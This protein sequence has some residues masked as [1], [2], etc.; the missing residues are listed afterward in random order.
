MPNFRAAQDEIL[1]STRLISELKSTVRN[2]EVDINLPN[3]KNHFDSELPVKN[4]QQHTFCVVTDNDNVITNN[5]TKSRRYVYDQN[6][7]ICTIRANFAIVAIQRKLVCR[8]I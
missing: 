4:N 1:T 6:L 8:N 7:T 2:Q 3:T 5:R